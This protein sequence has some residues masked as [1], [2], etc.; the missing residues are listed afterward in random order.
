MR[1]DLLLE[2]LQA[3]TGVESELIQQPAAGSLVGVQRVGLSAVA[4]QG[5]HQQRRHAFTCW[6]GVH[7][8][9]Q[10]TDH[11]CRCAELEAGREV[12]FEEPEPDLLEPDAVRGDPFAVAGMAQHVASE[13]GQ[14]PR[15]RL[16]RG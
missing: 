5:D 10:V 1:Q 11:L 4:V 14:C 12:G 3:R 6:V 8:R 2:L 7:E 16:E 13:E 15:S 9:F